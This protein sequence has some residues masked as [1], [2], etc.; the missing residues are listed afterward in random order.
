MAEESLIPPEIQAML[1]QEVYFPGEEVIDRSSIRRYAQAIMDL[2]PMYWDDI[3]ANEGP[4]GSIIAPP[5]YIFDVSHNICA[6]V[7]EDGRDLSR[8]TIPGMNP[9]R[10]S[11]EYHF[12][13]PARPGDR[14]HAKR[15]IVDI[16]EKQGRRSGRILFVVYE[17][18]YTNQAEIILG[19]CRETMLFLE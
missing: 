2:N 14:V 13:E 10:G 3:R 8:V 6:E 12:F 15:K 18:T 11:N 19:I 1:G 16:Y 7:G 17:T 5:T 4:Y 9:V